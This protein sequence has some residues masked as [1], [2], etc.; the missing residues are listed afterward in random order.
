MGISNSKLDR[1]EEIENMQPLVTIVMLTYNAKETIYCAI[2]SVLE[3]TYSNI[4]LIISDDCSENFDKSKIVQYIEKNVKHNIKRCIV[5]KNDNNVGTVK[6]ENLVYGIASGEY[7]IELAGDDV[8]FDCKVVENIIK[9]MEEDNLNILATRRLVCDNNL[10]PLFFWPHIL[11]RRKVEELNTSYKQ[12][13]ALVTNQFYDMV[14]GSAIAYRKSLFDN[15]KYDEKYV[16]TEDFPFFTNYTWNNIIYYSHEIV[17]I[18]YRYG[19]VSNTSHPK[20]V[21]DMEYYNKTD[22]IKHY[23]E[24]DRLSKR[25]IDYILERYKIKNR[26]E[27]VKL[28]IRYCDIIFRKAIYKIFRT[29]CKIYD[30]LYLMMKGNNE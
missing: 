7:I 9:R 11:E 8:F 4:E 12:Y 24:L 23:G 18:K 1:C 19:G 28:Y 25:K 15:M 13:V 22:R 29:V 3:Q 26:K 20:A 17:S 16:L 21:A 27:L 14:S 30:R 10:K 5:R 2:D 6:H